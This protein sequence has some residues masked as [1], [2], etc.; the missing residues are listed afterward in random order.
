MKIGI[1]LYSCPDKV[2][3]EQSMVETLKALAGMGYDGVEFFTYGAYGA[4]DPQELKA[5]LSECG[6]EAVNVHLHIPLEQWFGDMNG[7]LDYARQA[8]LPA[9][10]LP[11][12]HEEQRSP[13]L[14]ARIIG[15]IPR[16]IELCGEYGLEFCYHNHDF[17]FQPYGD[18]TL[19]AAIAGAAPDM[20]IEL[21]TFW[22][23]FAGHDP[24]AVM[25]S[26]ENKLRLVHVKDYLQ[27]ASFYE[28]K[29]TAV[30]TGVMDNAAVVSKAAAMG[31][32]W[33]IVEQDNSPID[34]L[35]SARL[36]IQGI[37][38]LLERGRGNE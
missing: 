24:C 9:V 23:H 35:D 14:F 15:E 25:D 33:V 11:Y 31:Q 21:D 5:R 6:L 13:E 4:M 26:L 16:W 2:G 8:G 29:F 10:T 27:L 36:S 20:K 30:G 34:T 22:A 38:R 28:M 17:E 12:I 18:G 19:L 1:Q 3:D 37:R 7:V 32:E